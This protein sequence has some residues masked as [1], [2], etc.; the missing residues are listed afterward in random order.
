MLPQEHIHSRVSSVGNTTQLPVRVLQACTGERV[1]VNV[2]LVHRD[3][4]WHY[5]DVFDTAIAGVPGKAP[6]ISIETPITRSTLPTGSARDTVSVDGNDVSVSVIDAGLPVIFVAASSLGLP[7][8]EYLAPVQ[9]L[10]TNTAMHAAAERVRQ[11]V[12][13][14][15]DALA[16]TLSE[17]APKI[18]IIHPRAAYTTSGGEEL[19]AHDA[20]MLVRAISVGNVHRSVPATT[21]AAL[22]ASM[23]YPDSLIGDT[24][25]L[26]GAHES[27]SA[28]TSAL[29]SASTRAITV[30]HPAGAASASVAL[31]NDTPAALLYT[32]TARR[33]MQGMVEVAHESRA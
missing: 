9:T 8:A 14:K 18:C 11:Q 10:D 1:I 25:R 2:P 15:F 4:A 22:A 16:G 30:G 5:S 21:L 19:A 7:S 23:S 13:L 17:S 6:G 31:K 3:G 32:R 33:I 28:A 20:D 27:P 12:A 29:V 24:L 26:G